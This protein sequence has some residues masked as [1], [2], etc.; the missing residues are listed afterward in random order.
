MG[1]FLTNADIIHAPKPRIWGEIT[2]C[3]DFDF[4]VNEI[5]GLLGGKPH[6]AGRQRDMRVNPFTGAKN[7]GYWEYRTDVVSDYDCSCVLEEIHRFV[8]VHKEKLLQIKR[9]YPCDV[10]FRLYADAEREA[11]APA[12]RLEQP[13]IRDAALLD[14]IIDVIVEFERPEEESGK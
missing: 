13:I 3:F 1:V 5:T 2:L 6:D 11:D 4:D 12:I 8:E 14:A 9:D 7:P 10:F